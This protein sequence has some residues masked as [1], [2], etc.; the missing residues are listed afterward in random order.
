MR[1]EERE[2]TEQSPDLANRLYQKANAGCP[3]VFAGFSF[4]SSSF[5]KE[6]PQ[7]QPA[8]VG[9]DHLLTFLKPRVSFFW[10][11]RVCGDSLS[12]LG[13]Q[14]PG[15]TDTH[16]ASSPLRPPSPGRAGLPRPSRVFL[17]RLRPH[18]ATNILSGKSHRRTLF[19]LE[20]GMIPSS[21]TAGLLGTQGGRWSR[22]GPGPPSLVLSLSAPVVS[23]LECPGRRLQGLDS[24]SS[25][26]SDGH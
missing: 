6:C 22:N 17:L 10:K 5:S 19:A 23:P 20:G 11:S 14:S 4:P 16:A 9:G 18:D 24:G 7:P 15:K 21:P 26:S 25:S 8:K 2:L 1:G 13:I 3:R 12:A